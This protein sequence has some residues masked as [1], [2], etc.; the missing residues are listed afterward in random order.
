R[1]LDLLRHQLDEIDAAQVR[2][3]E[4]AELTAEA[5]RLANA[6]ALQRAPP[7]PHQLLEDDGDPGAAPALGAAARAVHGPGGHDRALAELA[8][9]A[10]ALAPRVRHL[11]ATPRAHARAV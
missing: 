8:E 3:G 7:P 10:Q 4:S 9:R 1:E 2:V 6:E 5:E 11:G